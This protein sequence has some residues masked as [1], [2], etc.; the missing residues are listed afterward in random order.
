MMAVLAAHDENA[1]N[2]NFIQFLPLIHRGAEDELKFV[3]KA[4]NWALR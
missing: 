2:K 3:K 4:L 1:K